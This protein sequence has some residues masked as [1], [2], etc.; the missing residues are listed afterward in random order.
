MKK[1]E[2]FEHT[3]NRIKGKDEKGN[4][5]MERTQINTDG[6]PDIW[7]MVYYTPCPDGKEGDKNASTS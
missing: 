6:T 7:E 3:P 5:I 4:F 1:I 2:I